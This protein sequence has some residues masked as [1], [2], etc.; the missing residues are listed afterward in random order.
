[1]TTKLV[2]ICT[3]LG[4]L[5]SRLYVQQNTEAIEKVDYAAQVEKYRK[6]KN[7]G[8]ALTVV[9]SVLFVSGLVTM[10]NATDVYDG[11]LGTGAVLFVGGCVSLGAG[12]PLWIVG[13]VQQK[14]YSAKPQQ[15]SVRINATPQNQGLTLTY[16]F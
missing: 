15:L 4:L 5:N 7:V 2:I 3:V 10:Y 11:I 8:T 14:K 13:G 9:G 12:I 16:R 6:M 1:M